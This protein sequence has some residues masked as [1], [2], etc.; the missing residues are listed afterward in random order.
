[1]EFIGG[2]KTSTIIGVKNEI[3]GGIATKLHRGASYKKAPT[4]MENWQDFKAEVG[5]MKALKLSGSLYHTVK[6]MGKMV[7]AGRYL[8][9]ANHLYHEATKV[10]MTGTEEA[11][12]EAADFKVKAKESL[13]EAGK[14]VIKGGKYL[15]KMNKSVWKNGVFQVKA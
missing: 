15:V 5:K 2:M 9:E 7:Y 4:D 12:I 3:I 1:M 14:Q 11:M 8:L 13:T 6:G 10:G